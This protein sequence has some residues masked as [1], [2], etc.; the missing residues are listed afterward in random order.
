[1]QAGKAKTGNLKGEEVGIVDQITIVGTA[2]PNLQR[3]NVL[4]RLNRNPVVGDKFS[5]RHGQKGVLSQLWPDVN[6]PYAERTGMR[7]DLIINPHAFPSRM[8]IGMLIESMGSKAG[9]LTGRN[10]R[11][12]TVLLCV[13][14]IE[15]YARAASDC[16]Y[17]WRTCASEVAVCG[18][19]RTD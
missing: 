12:A 9:A 11:T 2:D 10:K 7:P 14:S 3:A 18:R 16:C 1:M 8:T 13:G 4:M 6:M 17:Y 15:G 5:S 19:R